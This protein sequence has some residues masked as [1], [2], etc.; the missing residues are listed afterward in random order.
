MTTPAS[1]SSSVTGAHESLGSAGIPAREVAG[2]NAGEVA[3]GITGE[4]A[5][6]I[7]D[8]NVRAPSPA[9]A[10][11]PGLAAAAP[12]DLA[13]VAHPVLS[14]AGAARFEAALFGGDEAREWAAMQQAARAIAAAVL[15]DFEEIGPL[16]PEPRI[17][18]LAGKGHNG[19]DALLAAKFIHEKHP[20][21]RIETRLVFGERVLRPLALRAWREL[22]HAAR[23]TG[24]PP[25]KAEPPAASAPSASPAPPAPYDI[26]LDGIFGFQF[27]PPVEPRVAALLARANASPACL[28]AAVDLPSGLGTPDVFQADFTYATGV[29]KSPALAG[30][31]A[32]A[33]GRLRYL[34][35]GFFN[36]NEYNTGGGDGAGGDGGG[37][38]NP[39]AP[40]PKNPNP[41]FQKNLKF[42]NPK[43]QKTAGDGDGDGDA[44]NNDR[45]IAAAAIRAPAAAIL[46]PAVLSPLRALRPPLTDKRDYGH[47]FIVGGSRGCPGAV[48]MAALAALRSGAG[49]VTVFVPETLAAACAARAPEAMWVAWPETPG[50]GLA[51]EGAHLFRERAARATALLAGP[52]LGREAETLALAADL[53]KIS[54]VPLVLDADALR[55]SIVGAG[56]APRILTPHAGEFARIAGTGDDA[57]GANPKSQNPKSQKNLKFQNPKF[58]KTAGAGAVVVVLKGPVTRIDDGGATVLHSLFGGPVLAR[59][60]SG[61]LLA[62]LIGGLLAQTPAQPLLAACRGAVWH[63]LAADRLARAQGQRAVNITRLLDHLAGVLREDVPVAGGGA[64][65]GQVTSAK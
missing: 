23:D 40:N 55:P 47:L 36:N 31:N 46:T 62:G 33:V 2:E 14:T 63:G 6:K 7:A 9:T 42:Q 1:K 30:E 5:D 65:A 41:K 61:D 34:D 26:I 60:G 10:M 16:P 27:R 39:Q 45:A 28:R 13:A 29:V 25:V 48:L 11:P 53:A 3:R 50:G 51:P 49:L 58:Q 24:V 52:G 38:A 59:G 57:K 22:S 8:K 18:V 54:A 12:S 37:G 20:R 21:A 56:A 15:R 64:A 43:F 32:G 44:T 4:V 35:L 17:L 19:G